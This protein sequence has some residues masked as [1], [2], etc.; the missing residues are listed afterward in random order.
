MRQQV[1][2]WQKNSQ[3]ISGLPWER[4]H[5]ELRNEPPLDMSGVRDQN[6]FMAS[7]WIGSG[8][9]WPLKGLGVA[10]PDYQ[11]G[12]HFEALDKGLFKATFKLTGYFFPISISLEVR[13]LVCKMINFLSMATVLQ[14][15]LKWQKNIRWISRVP[16]ERPHLELRNE[17]PLDSLEK[18]Y[19]KPF[20]GQPLEQAGH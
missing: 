2:K 1:F 18:P 9:G 8:A 13:C 5:S 17:P 6:P 15:N 10:S 3:K 4:P 7:L 20:Y 11:V 14:G 16:W 19:P 12:A